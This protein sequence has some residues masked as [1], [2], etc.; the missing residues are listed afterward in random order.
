MK[1]ELLFLRYPQKP[2]QSGKLYKLH[3]Y[4][5]KDLTEIEFPCFTFFF[6]KLQTSI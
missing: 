4:R 2:G 6:T 3:K 1:P 5:R